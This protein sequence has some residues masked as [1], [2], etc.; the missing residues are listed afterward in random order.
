MKTEYSRRIEKKK[1]EVSNFIK[2]R[3]V[4]AELFRADRRTAMM[5]LII[6]IAILR[7]HLKVFI[8][9]LSGEVRRE[10]CNKVSYILRRL[11]PPLRSINIQCVSSV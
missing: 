4:G 10:M 2:I 1:P 3:P 8:K 11:Y 9:A 6:A 5:K 7:T